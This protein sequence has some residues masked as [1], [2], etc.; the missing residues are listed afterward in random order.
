MGFLSSCGCVNTT[1]WIHYMDANKT[2]REIARWK[3]YKNATSYLERNPGSNTLRINSCS[4]TY[5]PSQK[6]SELDE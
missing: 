3:Q 6:L 4:V 5:L 2:Q 1:V